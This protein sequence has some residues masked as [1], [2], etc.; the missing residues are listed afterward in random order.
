M[1][2]HFSG[3]Q[4]VSKLPQVGNLFAQ[5]KQLKES[6]NLFKLFSSKNHV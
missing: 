3:H 5:R 4:I 6:A 2:K 1:K